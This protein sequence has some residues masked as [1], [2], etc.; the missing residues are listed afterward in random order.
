[1]P[2][3]QKFPG[4]KAPGPRTMLWRLHLALAHKNHM[5]WRL[6]LALGYKN[7][8]LWRL[9]LPGGPPGGLALFLVCVA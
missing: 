5:L 9:P 3:L 4:L 1:L 7:H 6:H 8:M 2:I